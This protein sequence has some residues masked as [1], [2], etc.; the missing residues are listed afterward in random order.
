MKAKTDERYMA[1]LVVLCCAVDLGSRTITKIAG[2]DLS[3]RIENNDLS[4]SLRDILVAKIGQ[5]LCL[6]REG[7]NNAV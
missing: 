4:V 2:N 5:R 6:H 3:T 1:N 7:K